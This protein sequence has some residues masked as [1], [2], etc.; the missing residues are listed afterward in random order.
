MFSP[1][2]AWARRRGGTADPENHVA[3]N[4]A[5]YGLGGPGWTMTER[6]RAALSRTADTLRIGPSQVH[7]DGAALRVDIDEITV[8]LPRRLRGSI[9]L[10]PAALH[11]TTYPIDAQGAHRWTPIA[12]CARAEVNLDLPRWRWSGHAYADSNEGDGPLERSFRT[13][14]WSRATLRDG[15]T[16]IFYDALRKDGSRLAL[17]RRFD[18]DGGSQAIPM[19]PRASLHRG[20]WGMTQCAH[21]ETVP[22]VLRRFEDAPFYTR[23]TLAS[24]IEGEDAVAMHESLSLEKFDRRWVQAMLPFRMP[25]L[26]RF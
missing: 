21:G 2:Y 1:Y 19:P 24:R 9:T 3:L 18:V 13:W 11:D 7:W 25:R 5:L 14:D 12:P 10:H 6:G 8:P 15:S 16:A 17:A 20:A 4:V 26:A 22:R 23:S